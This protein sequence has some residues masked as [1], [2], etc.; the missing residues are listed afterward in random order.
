MALFQVASYCSCENF[1]F[2]DSCVVLEYDVYTWC[3]YINW[4]C[5]TSMD[6]IFSGVSVAWQSLLSLQVWGLEKMHCLDHSRYQKGVEEVMVYHVETETT[7]IP[8][9]TIN[10]RPNQFMVHLYWHNFW[11]C[12]WNVWFD[13]C[14]PSTI[15]NS[16]CH[17]FYMFCLSHTH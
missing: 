15:W 16:S 13:V 3:W 10:L 5:S 6:I 12:E 11:D 17:V 8:G 14:S 7:Y 2:R 1:F 9:D 4:V